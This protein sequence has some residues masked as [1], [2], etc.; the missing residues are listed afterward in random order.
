MSLASDVLAQWERDEPRH[1]EYGRIIATDVRMV[2]RDA[3]VVAERVSPR[4]KDSD[5]IAKKVLRK[6]Y[7][8]YSQV[9][10]K[11]GVRVV[12]RVPSDVDRAVSALHEHFGGEIDDKRIALNVETFAYR[13]VHI[14]V[15]GRCKDSDWEGLECELQVRTISEDAWATMAH[16]LA[17]K[18]VRDTPY[19]HRRAL[20]ALAALLELAD[21][22]YEDLFQEMIGDPSY[23]ALR[24]LSEIEGTFL[25]LGGDSFD[26]VLS[27]DVIETLDPAFPGLDADAISS[28]AVEWA[29]SSRSWLVERLRRRR[30]NREGSIFLDQPEILLLGQLLS[31]HSSVLLPL[32]SDAFDVDELERI[33]ENLAYPVRD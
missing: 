4:I 6:G 19:L 15:Y 26:R 24:V 9:T 7:G 11:V 17:Y 29:E 1:R 30:D 10:D 8:A 33:A 21:L 23:K 22:R 28:K 31:S 20:A 27:Q 3:R 14:Q 5:S 16:F 25:S 32:W 18:G 13:S 2:L 12:V